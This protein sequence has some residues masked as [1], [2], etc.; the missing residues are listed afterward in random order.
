MQLPLVRAAYGKVYLSI[1]GI[2]L[3]RMLIQDE[4]NYHKPVLRN[5]RSQLA[6]GYLDTLPVFRAL[7]GD[8]KVRGV[9]S[10]RQKWKRP[11]GS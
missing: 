1:W 9:I 5:C 7:I 11:L 4:A 6:L 3:Q 10:L 2:E 8:V